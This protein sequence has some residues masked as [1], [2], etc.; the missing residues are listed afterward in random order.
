M[1]GL[2]LKHINLRIP[3]DHPEFDQLYAARLIELV[4]TSPLTAVILAHEQPYDAEGNLMDT[5]RGLYVP[6]DYVLKL[7]RENP[8]LLPGVSI[9][10]GRRD[11]LAEL[12]RCLAGGA[13]LMKCLPNCQNIDCGNSKYA[14]FWERM[15]EAGLP[16]LAHTGG[17][18]TVPVINPAYANPRNLTLPLECGVNVIA[19]HCGT[20]SGPGD[21]DYFGWFQAMTEQF[22]NLY[23]D[24]SALNLA[25]RS[26]AL[27]HCLKQ[28]LAPCV[29]H[30]SD[31]PVPIQ[32]HWAFLRGLLPW[33]AYR[34]FQKIP[35]PIER[36]YRLKLAMG[37][38]PD[39]FTRA[40]SLL[41]QPH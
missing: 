21:P 3:L 11:A 41:R 38:P 20:K 31:F 29:V 2:I 26:R 37:F 35:N 25:L 19:A 39:H 18:Y 14:K 15:A 28:P 33:R 6:N 5:G 9:H 27:S 36:D 23:G 4:N 32:G 13:V 40:W 34:G 22:P 8:R 16:L 7:A 17:E 30:G 24:T 12:E 1:A 10:P